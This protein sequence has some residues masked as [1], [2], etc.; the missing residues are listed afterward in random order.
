[1]GGRN[2]FTKSLQFYLDALNEFDTKKIKA[3]LDDVLQSIKKE[4]DQNLTKLKYSQLKMM[5]SM[6][7]SIKATGQ[8]NPQML[9]R[10]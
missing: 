8:R 5:K 2:V 9:M 1:M 10:R 6:F 7:I 4:I 3:A